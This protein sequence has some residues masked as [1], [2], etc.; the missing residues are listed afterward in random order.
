MNESQIAAAAA[1]RDQALNTPD[2]V[3]RAFLRDR[4]EVA[5][6]TLQPL[7]MGILYL[8]Q[9]I[10]H[11]FVRKPAIG[12]DGKPVPHEVTTKDAMRAIYIF[13]APSAARDAI[14]ADVL[15]AEAFALANTISPF[16]MEAIAAE[17]GQIFTDGFSTMP[18]GGI[19]EDPTKAARPARPVRPSKT[20]G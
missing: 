2:E 7:T 13:H 18:G 3:R 11:P 19:D 12:A 5:G 16:D 6:V 8:L 9:E 14:E 17:L 10:D 20:A 1:A 15:D 4:Y